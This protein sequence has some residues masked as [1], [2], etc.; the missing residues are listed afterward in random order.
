[1]EQGLLLYEEYIEIKFDIR[2][3]RLKHRGWIFCY[4]GNQT[5]LL[6]DL[7]L[8]HSVTLDTE[9]ITCEAERG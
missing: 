1:M 6:C 9:K 8:V 3:V 2:T 4:Q 7:P 5:H